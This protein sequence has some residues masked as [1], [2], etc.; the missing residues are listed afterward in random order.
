MGTTRGPSAGSRSSC[1]KKRTK[2]WVVLI[3]RPSAVGSRMALKISSAG[4]V[5]RSS[6]RVRRCGR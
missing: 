4:T 3:S 1:V 6:A 2:A 5:K